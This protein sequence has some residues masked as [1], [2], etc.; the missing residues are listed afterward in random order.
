MKSI[1]EN[2]VTL[3]GAELLAKSEMIGTVFTFDPAYN[4]AFEGAFDD[5]KTRTQTDSVFVSN[6]A[7]ASNPAGIKVT[8]ANKRRLHELTIVPKAKSTNK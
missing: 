7:S 4:F 3:E 1:N 8:F 2:L 5:T 6:K